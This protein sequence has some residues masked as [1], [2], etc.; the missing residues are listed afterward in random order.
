MEEKKVS[1]FREKN[2]AAMESPE[3]MNDYLRVTSPGI[4]LILAAAILILIGVILW[5]VL[6]RI[7][8]SLGVAVVADGEEC[9]CLV[10]YTS[11]EA[12]MERDTVT[13]DGQ[14]YP[15]HTDADVETVIVTE[16]M[17]PYI[18]VAG[19]LSIGDVAVAIPVGATLSQGVYTGTVVTESLRPMSLLLQ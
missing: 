13:I 5:S 12:I 9:V 14:E 19:N 3:S 15:L 2:I 16:E 6:G 11:L 17:S 4:W 1:L 10:P 8:T 18:R 7:N